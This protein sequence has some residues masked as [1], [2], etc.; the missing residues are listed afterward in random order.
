MAGDLERGWEFR[1]AF[2]FRRS[3]GLGV[4]FH[5]ANI[6]LFLFLLRF[7]STSLLFSSVSFLFISCSFLSS[8][9]FIFRLTFDHCV[10]SSIFFP[11][12]LK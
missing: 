9:F 1:I 4:W 7:F 12:F 8:G 11:F 2:A 5:L 10:F 6:I 3:W